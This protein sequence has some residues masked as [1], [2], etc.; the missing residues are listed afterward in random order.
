MNIKKSLNIQ[1]INT[2]YVTTNSKNLILSFLLK[3]TNSLLLAIL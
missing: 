1:Q 2:Y 3:I